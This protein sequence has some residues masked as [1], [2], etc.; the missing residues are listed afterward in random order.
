MKR[1][2]NTNFFRIIYIH[3]FHFYVNLVF[4][5]FF[6]NPFYKLINRSIWKFAVDFSRWS[7]VIIIYMSSSYK[8]W[9]IRSGVQPSFSR[10]SLFF[11]LG[12]RLIFSNS[13]CCLIFNKNNFN[14]RFSPKHHL[15]Y[16]IIPS[17]DGSNQEPFL[18]FA[19]L[20]IK[21]S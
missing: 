3:Y 2:N 13:I 6:N 18:D 17:F 11:S 9:N 16:H 10:S 15:T 21:R 12:I 20:K 19:T 4:E 8:N 5:F 7:T 14:K 1:Q